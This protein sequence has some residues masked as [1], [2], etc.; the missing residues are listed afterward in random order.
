MTSI[1]LQ[2]ILYLM[3]K[4]MRILVVDDSTQMRKLM[5]ML[6]KQLNFT[7]VTSASDGQEAWDMLNQTP[8]DIVV[9]D[10]VMDKMSG[11]DLLKKMRG[12][13]TFKHTPFLM[14]TATDDKDEIVSAVKE[15][16]NGYILKPPTQEILEPKIAAAI[17]HATKKKAAEPPSKLAPSPASAT[18]ITGPRI[19]RIKADLKPLIPDFL[20]SSHFEIKKLNEELSSGRYEEIL[21]LGTSIRGSATSYGFLDLA[22]I[23]LKIEQAAKSKAKRSDIKFFADQL[24]ACVS[25][26]EIEYVP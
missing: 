4:E 5:V 20:I 24:L 11:L 26:I 1:T 13:I 14:V 7:N 12:H 8:A 9:S 10:W 25:N 22:G 15:G 18:S 19:I 16:V 2:Y 3:N 21:R 6:L 23:A 17:D